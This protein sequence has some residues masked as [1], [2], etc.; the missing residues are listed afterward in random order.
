MRGYFKAIIGGI[1]GAVAAGIWLTMDLFLPEPYG[2]FLLFGLMAMVHIIIGWQVGRLLEKKDALE[3]TEKGL[4]TH[5]N[6][7]ETVV[8]K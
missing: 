4:E 7:T 3:A 6:H 8:E 2:D 1:L 5:A